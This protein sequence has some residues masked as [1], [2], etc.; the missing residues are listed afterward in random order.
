MIEANFPS[1]QRRKFIVSLPI[2]PPKPIFQE[3]CCYFFA[4]FYYTNV[5]KNFS[6]MT[7]H[8]QVAMVLAPTFLLPNFSCQPASQPASIGGVFKHKPKKQTQGHA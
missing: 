2:R 5:S 7:L 8:K 6:C 3:H 1:Y 4:V